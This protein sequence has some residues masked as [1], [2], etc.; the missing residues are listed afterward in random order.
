MDE[1]LKKSLDALDAAADELIKKSANSKDDDELKPDDIS[2]P[3][4]VNEYVDKDENDE[5]NEDEGKDLKKSDEDSDEDEDNSDEDEDTDEDEDSED[6]D[7]DDSNE[8]EDKDLNKSDEPEII[9]GDDDDQEEGKKVIQK[10]VDENIK[11]NEDLG[12]SLKTS[13][14]Q[15]AIVDIVIKSIGQIEKDM[16]D[17][18]QNDDYTSSVL[19]KSLKAVI[20]HN[21]ALSDE[22]SKLKQ[23]IDGLK[24]SMTKGF[25]D[26]M[27]AIEEISVEPSRM[28]KSVGNIHVHDRNFN[29]SINGNSVAGIE[30]LQ[31]SQVLGVLNAELYAGNQNV[32]VQDIISYE[33]GAP[34]RPELHSLVMSKCNI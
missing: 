16:F 28:R 34:L 14:F 32:S 15:S 33:S 10:I 27:T 6:E 31:K 21:N 23:R 11:K 4:E 26:I 19:A 22:N 29:K 9:S 5:S 13:E 18:G 8:D 3:D 24:E 17:K 20:D 30:S 12:K 1:N 7:S 25:S 2:E